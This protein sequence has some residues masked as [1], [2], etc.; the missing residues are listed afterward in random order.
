[1]R[2]TCAVPR[3][4]S[5]GSVHVSVST[6]LPPPRPHAYR[7]AVF[8]AEAC[9]L[10]VPL[11]FAIYLSAYFQVPGP[12]GRKPEGYTY[13]QNGQVGIARIGRHTARGHTNISK[14]HP[15]WSLWQ[16]GADFRSR[17]EGLMG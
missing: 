10:P 13:K 11:D 7:P 9:R 14:I 6:K 16:E 17:M 8:N 1:M 12:D 15:M 3:I 2:T 4:S 5:L